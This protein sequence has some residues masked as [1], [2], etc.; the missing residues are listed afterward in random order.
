MWVSP[1]RCP[2]C[3]AAFGFTMKFG[4]P[5]CG[6]T[7][8][9]WNMFRPAELTA[10]RREKVF[11]RDGRRC[12]F[13]G[14]HGLEWDNPLSIDHITPEI[15]G[16][17]HALQ[18]LQTLCRICNSRKSDRSAEPAPWYGNLAPIDLRHDPERVQRRLARRRIA[19][20]ET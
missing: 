19:S 7:T 3:D 6:Y 16:G 9:D 10:A 18:N 5:T 4:C 2:D 11:E 15:D 17:T 13:C 1:E 8:R 20:A 14:C 12:V